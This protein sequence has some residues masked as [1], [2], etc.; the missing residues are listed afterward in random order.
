MAIVKFLFFDPTEGFPREQEPTDELSLGKVTASGVGGV[1]FDASSQLIVNVATPVSGTDAANKDYVDNFVQ[2]LDWKQ[3]VRAVAISAITLSGEQTIDGVA[4]VDGDRVLVTAQASASTN[5]IYVAHTGAWVR[6]TDADT[7]AEVT[8]SLAAFVEEGTLYADT[9]WTL[10]TD[11][12]ITLGT[13][14]LTF[15]QFTGFGALIAGAGILKTGNQIDV[16]LNTA[17]AAQTAGVD[18]GSS[19]LEF[20]VTG[21]AGKL[22]VAVNGTAG[23]ERTAS[24]LGILLDNTPDTLSSSAA[25]LKVIGL[26]LEFLIND[27]ATTTNV[28]ATNLNTLVADPSSDASGLHFHPA[29]VEYWTANGAIAKGEAVYISAN[30][31]VSTGSFGAAATARIIGIANAA[32]VDTSNGP[33]VSSGVVTGILT[34]ATFNTP[35]FLGT[36][37]TPVPYSSVVATAGA[38]QVR[39]GYAK[40]AT[41]LEVRIMDFGQRASA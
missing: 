23:I 28:T 14:A 16:E 13:T 4:V 39:L 3:S 31:A 6:A 34:G 25:G 12:P 2:G 1:A 36:D 27:V 9:G 30:N 15:T 10:T 26:P 32:I 29:A 17:A 40:N 18:G 8:A 19:G 21:A 7:S 38:R 37:G 41:D 22:Q 11:N 20:D 5:G 35:Y 24:G 33:I